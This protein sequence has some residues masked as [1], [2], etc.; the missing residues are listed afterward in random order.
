MGFVS[1]LVTLIW[2][3][4][5]QSAVEQPVQTRLGLSGVPAMSRA[6]PGAGMSW[7]CPKAELGSL[8]C[9]FVTVISARPKNPKSCGWNWPGLEDGVSAWELLEVVQ[10][11]RSPSSPST[12]QLGKVGLDQS[13]K[14]GSNLNNFGIFQ[15]GLL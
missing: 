3:I 1:Q 2:L 7:G 5:E 6:V 14:L 15:Q 4:V 12:P 11:S 8:T 13:S 9:T 10:H